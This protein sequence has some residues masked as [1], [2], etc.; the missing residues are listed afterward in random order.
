MQKVHWQ[1]PH[2]NGG[3][4]G[5]GFS[6]EHMSIKLSFWEVPYKKRIRVGVI[7]TLLRSPG[8]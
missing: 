2:G 3:T 5:E 4:S 8:A 7:P 6:S 1:Y